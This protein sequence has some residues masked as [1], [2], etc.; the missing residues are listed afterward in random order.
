[1]NGQEWKKIA[2]SAISLREGFG[3]IISLCE[4]PKSKI[5]PPAGE[6]K[7]KIPN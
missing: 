4:N 5:H 1:M 6:P 3:L 7:F 2:N